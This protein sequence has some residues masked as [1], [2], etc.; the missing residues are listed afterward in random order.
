MNNKSTHIPNIVGQALAWLDKTK[1]AYRYIPES[2]LW[3]FVYDGLYML[4]MNDCKD[5][6]FGLYAPVLITDS[7]DEEIQKMVYD[8]S[9]PSIEQEFSANCDFGYHG[10]GLCHVAQWWGIQSNS[11]R[12][13]KKV[14]ME[15]LKEMHEYQIKLYFIL[16]CTYECM[17]NPPQEVLKDI[18]KDFKYDESD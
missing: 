16:H 14:F 6:E 5:N 13:T 7:D 15:K 3:E 1:I 18:F 2:E 12:L 8:C 10:E 9:V 17:F 11:P 4:L